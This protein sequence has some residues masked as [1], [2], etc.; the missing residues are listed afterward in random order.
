MIHCVLFINMLSCYLK[1]FSWG[2]GASSK[3][4]RNKEGSII[5]SVIGPYIGE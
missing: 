2:E 1:F 3:T 4:L 5:S